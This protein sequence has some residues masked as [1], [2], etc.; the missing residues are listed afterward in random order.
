M[1]LLRYAGTGPSY[2]TGL[3][4]LKLVRA[5]AARNYVRGSFSHWTL[6]MNLELFPVLNQAFELLTYSTAPRMSP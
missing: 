5:V 3:L 2:L 4:S 1:A 6:G